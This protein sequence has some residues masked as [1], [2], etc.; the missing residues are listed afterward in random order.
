[1]LNILFYSIIILFLG[2]FSPGLP[3]WFS[4]KIVHL[5]FGL[6]LLSVD[7]NIAYLRYMVYLVSGSIFIILHKVPLFR[8]SEKKDIGI[9]NYILVTSF[10]VYNKIPLKYISVLYFSDP[11]GA[12]VGRL[13]GKN[14]IKYT[15]K[16]LEGSLAVFSTSLFLLYGTLGYKIFN[17]FMITLIELY[18]GKL[19]NII[20]GFYL[21]LLYYLN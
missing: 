11:S 20:I 2:Q 5:G 18:S 4:R 17:A 9:I 1:M 7:F 12:I 10:C 15:N 14:K 3:K 8:F 19:D 16:S 13:Y 21:I 6:I